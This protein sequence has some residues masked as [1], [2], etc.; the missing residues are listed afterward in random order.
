MSYTP[1]APRTHYVPWTRDETEMLMDLKRRGFTFPQISEHYTLQ[2]RPD[3]TAV[4]C[5]TRYTF[6]TANPSP[7]LL[8]GDEI[9]LRRIY[10]E[11]F[12]KL[13]VPARDKLL[14][15]I[16]I[17]N[18][19]PEVTFNR[20]LYTIRSFNRDEACSRIMPV[21]DGTWQSRDKDLL[22]KLLY[23]HEID[24]GHRMKR[25]GPTTPISTMLLHVPVTSP[26]SGIYPSGLQ[27]STQCV[28][29]RSTI[30]L[31]SH[32]AL[33]R[34]AEAFI[35]SIDP[36]WEPRHKPLWW[37]LALQFPYQS[38]ADIRYLLGYILC[39]LHA[40]G[41]RAHCFEPVASSPGLC[42]KDL[43]LVRDILSTRACEEGKLLPQSMPSDKNPP[44]RDKIAST[45]RSR[46]EVPN[47]ISIASLIEGTSTSACEPRGCT[48]SPKVKLFK[49]PQPG[50]TAAPCKTKSNLKSH[51]TTHSEE[52]PYIC[53][54]ARCN[55]RFRRR[56]DLKRHKLVH[57]P[58][59]FICRVCQ[60]NFQRSDTLQRH[61]KSHQ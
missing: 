7:I 40:F 1:I 27:D 32:D 53:L 60:G 6:I 11:V 49:C 34:I 30:E 9:Y 38:L 23:I 13:K 24:I 37:P 39:D 31:L 19:T 17:T 58:P 57:G 21:I 4:A 50:C 44:R 18:W 36:E 26:A 56:K 54:T 15:A 47:R 16:E 25:F 52:R 46:P 28:Y 41:V 8:V 48:P 61:I 42:A 14:S 5:E 20:F 43:Q 45:Q 2:G 35:M 29:Y 55:M 33:P 12:R 59:R 10:Q 22:E 3:R 51:L